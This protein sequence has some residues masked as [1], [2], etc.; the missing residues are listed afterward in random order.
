MNQETIDEE[1]TNSMTKRL[2]IDIFITSIKYDIIYLKSNTIPH[3]ID[4][5][6]YAQYNIML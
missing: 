4:S 3:P 1:S 5:A 2:L 6:V